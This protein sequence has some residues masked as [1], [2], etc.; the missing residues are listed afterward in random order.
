MQNALQSQLTDKQGSGV[1]SKSS[2]NVD[3][4]FKGWCLSAGAELGGMWFSDIQCGILI[5]FPRHVVIFFKLCLF[6]IYI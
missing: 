4:E 1:E 2:E 3:S 5:L 6:C